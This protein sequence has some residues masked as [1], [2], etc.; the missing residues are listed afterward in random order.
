M[1]YRNI[2][3]EM[4]VWTSKTPTCKTNGLLLDETQKEF[5]RQEF[6]KNNKKNIASK[7]IMKSISNKLYHKVKNTL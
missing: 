6:K 3:K 1:W 5:H 2:R 7:S 4:Y